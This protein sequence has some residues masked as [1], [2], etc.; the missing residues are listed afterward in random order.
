MAERR[1]LTVEDIKTT[2]NVHEQ[3][4]RDW[5]KSGRLKGINFGGKTGWRVEEHDFD[6]FIEKMHKAPGGQSKAA[7]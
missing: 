4:V 1:F 3:T 2:L 7:A 6:A 5:L